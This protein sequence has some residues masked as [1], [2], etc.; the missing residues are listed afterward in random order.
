MG[1]ISSFQKLWK[2]KL[3]IRYF[4]V[5]EY[6]CYVFVPDDLRTKFDKKAIRCIF[7]GYDDERKGWRCCDPKIGRIHTSRNMVFDEASAWWPSKD[8]VQ[9]D[10]YQHETRVE[11]TMREDQ[12]ATCE[13]D[14]SPTFSMTRSPWHIGV[15]EG[16]EKITLNLLEELEKV[17]PPLQSSQMLQ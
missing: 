13:E 15:Y 2:M 9:P 10:T 16:D 11:D 4:R 5:F 8:K 17:P 3:T 12:D 1:Y 14:K 7:I 6:V